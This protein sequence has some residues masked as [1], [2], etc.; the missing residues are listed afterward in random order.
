MGTK[1][2]LKSAISQGIMYWFVSAE[3]EG[4]KRREGVRRMGLLVV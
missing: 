1:V 4:L 3:G 2:L